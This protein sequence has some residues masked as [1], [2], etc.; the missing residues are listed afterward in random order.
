[1]YRG[2]FVYIISPSTAGLR[3]IPLS[4]DENN[5]FCHMDSTIYV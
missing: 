2:I 1:M 5:V 3:K 4:L